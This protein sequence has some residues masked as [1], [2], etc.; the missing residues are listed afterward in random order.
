MTKVKIPLQIPMGIVK[1]PQEIFPHTDF[2][3]LAGF[4]WRQKI[5]LQGFSKNLKF[6][7]YL[8]M[9]R[10]HVNGV[11]VALTGAALL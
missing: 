11:Y 3:L 6:I 5:S 8:N 10:S 1:S 2:L 7:F 4:F 9:T